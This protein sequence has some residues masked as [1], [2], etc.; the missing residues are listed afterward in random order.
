MKYNFTESVIFFLTAFSIDCYS[1]N[2]PIR[3]INKND[4]IGYNT[5]QKLKDIAFCKCVSNGYSLDSVGIQDA[6]AW[7][8]NETLDCDL[9]PYFS[10]DSLTKTYVDLLPTHVPGAD[11]ENTVNK[12]IMIGCLNLYKSK[13]LDSFVRK[14]YK[15]NCKES[16]AP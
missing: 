11:L 13:M 16:N 15:N 4:S 2:I 10:I 3:P 6:S 1:Q 8:I 5:I 12:R 7:I 14:L 9:G